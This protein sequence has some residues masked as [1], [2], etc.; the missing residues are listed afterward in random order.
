MKSTLKNTL[1][2]TAFL[3]LLTSN[4]FAQTKEDQEKLKAKTDQKALNDLKSTTD[5]CPKSER[6][7]KRQAKKLNIPF[8]IVEKNGRISQLIDIE[9]DGT[10]IY[11]STEENSTINLK[12]TEELRTEE[13]SNKK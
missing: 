8:R 5:T 4:A 13:T 9:K 2:F 1:Y 6:R 3:L 12:N 7:L 10:P 11:I